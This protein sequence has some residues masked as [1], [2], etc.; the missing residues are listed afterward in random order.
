MKLRLIY[1]FLLALFAIATLSAQTPPRADRVFIVSFDGGKPAVI[2]NSDMPV[3]KKLVAEGACTWSARTVVPSIT[4]LSHASM[5]SGVGP[6]KHQITWNNWQPEKGLIPVPTIFSLAHPHGF[7]TAMFVGKPKFKHLNLPGSL[8]EFVL[9]LPTANAKDVAAAFA[10]RLPLLNVDLC[11]IHF[12][13]PDSTGHKYGWG[14]P[15]QK[16]AFANSDAALKIV[17]DALKAAGIADSSVVILTA[18]HGGHDKTHGSDSPEDV[19]IPWIVWG[20]G[21]KKDFKIT[22]PVSTCDTAATALW[23]LG[24]PIPAEFDGKPVTEA[25]E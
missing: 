10:A 3:L 4:L 5:I 23:L 20:K 8:D 7:R 15:E 22:T 1:P 12:A 6:A 14:S 25:F 9:P 11:L 24:L 17:M 2:A 16:Q 13:D 19:N 21:V 18:D